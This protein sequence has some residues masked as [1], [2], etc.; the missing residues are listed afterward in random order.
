MGYLDIKLEKK[1]MSEFENA[2]DTLLDDHLASI[3]TKYQ[4]RSL[5]QTNYQ[6][7]SKVLFEVV[8]RHHFRCFSLTIHPNY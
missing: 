6:V 5:F 1:K 8:G 4:R 2:T 7:H 3:Y